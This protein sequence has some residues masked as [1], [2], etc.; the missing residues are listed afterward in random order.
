MKSL[1]FILI[2]AVV[3][4]VIPGESSGGPMRGPIIGRQ[5]WR[6]GP[7]Q[8]KRAVMR[9]PVTGT[10]ALRRQ[11][12]WR[13]NTRNRDYNIASRNAYDRTSG[14]LYRT[15][16]RDFKNFKRY[17]G[18]EVIWRGGRQDLY[19]RNKPGEYFYR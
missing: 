11:P 12:I 7:V 9:G 10:R 15:Y 16:S 19:K 17:W 18:S 6:P 4:V 1:F 5:A 14:E 2:A 13:S 3:L 8:G